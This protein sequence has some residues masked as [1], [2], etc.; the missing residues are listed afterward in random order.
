MN[1]KTYNPSEKGYGNVSEWGRAFDERM[2][3]D[4]AKKVLDDDNPL[5]I[6]GFTKLPSMDELKSAY[7]KLMKIHHPDVVGGNAGT[8]MKIIAAYAVLEDRI[9]KA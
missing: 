4:E 6:M 8:A 1:Y 9:R 7:R 5:V 3:V 2:G